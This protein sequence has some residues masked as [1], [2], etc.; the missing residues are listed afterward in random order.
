MA[1]LAV[2]MTAKASI[3]LRLRL[4]HTNSTVTTKRTMLQLPRVCEGSPTP[5]NT[6]KY[7]F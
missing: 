3:N 7:P 2:I 4:T 6:K 1:T 5:Q